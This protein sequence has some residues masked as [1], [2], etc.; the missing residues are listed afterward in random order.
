MPASTETL[1]PRIYV[2]C[3]AAY[4]NGFLH[5]AWIDACDDLEKIR[6]QVNAM[7]KSSP[8]PDAE[9]FAIHDHE[10]FGGCDLGEYA[11]LE[12]AHAVAGFLIDTGKLGSLLLT[13]F[14]GNLE[15]AQNA[16][17]NYAGCYESSADFAQELTEETTTTPASLQYYIDYKSMARDME[18]NGDIIVLE[19]GFDRVHILWGR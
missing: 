7:L 15:D 14:S 11:G 19:E 1:N 13:H 2:A 16:L 10:D 18:L 8:V 9:E 4:N 12:R 6:A 17:E 5:G 3:L